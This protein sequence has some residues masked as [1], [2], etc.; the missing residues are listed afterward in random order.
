MHRMPSAAQ[1]ATPPG[2]PVVSI[3]MASYRRLSLLKSAVG[4][5]LA[6]DYSSYEVL[7]VDDGSDAETRAWLRSAQAGD[8]RLHVIFQEH[9]GVAEARARGVAEARGELVCILDSDDTL[10]PH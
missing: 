3:V 4:S 6:Q 10:V 8:S 7:V 2:A 1:H 9:L 5:A